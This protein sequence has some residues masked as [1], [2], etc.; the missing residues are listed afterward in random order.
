MLK[1]AMQHVEN[2]KK[3]A[4][5]SNSS[6]IDSIDND[7]LA[8]IAKLIIKDVVANELKNFNVFE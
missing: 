8:F 2:Y 7:G 3:A 6:S 4:K 5:D 1:N